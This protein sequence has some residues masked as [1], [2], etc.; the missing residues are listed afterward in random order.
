MVMELLGHVDYLRVLLVIRK[1][2]SLRFSQVQKALGLNPAQ[3]DRALKFL[4][5]GLW[6][7]PRT[8]PSEGTRIPVEYRLGKRGRSFLELFDNFTTGAQ[9][10]TEE[11]GAAEVEELLRLSA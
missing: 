8:V 6:I 5:K 11:L 7:V 1:E 3:V 2:G 10:R 4:T 9:R